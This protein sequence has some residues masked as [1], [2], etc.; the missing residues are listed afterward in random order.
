MDYSVRAA[1]TGEHSDNIRLASTATEDEWIH[2]ARLGMLMREQSSKLDLRWFS[3]VEYRDYRYDAFHDD[4][5]LM[6]NTAA[7]WTV[8]PQ[9]LNWVVE[10]YYGQALI[11]VTAAPTQDNL[12]DVNVLSLGPDAFWRVSERTYGRVGA[13]YGNYYTEATS[14]DADRYA[15]MASANY[16]LSSVTELSLNYD[17]LRAAQRDSENYRDYDRHNIFLGI[18]RRLPRSRLDLHVGQSLIRPEGEGTNTDHYWHAQWLRPVSP[19]TE[20]RVTATS[21]AQDA[22]DA[23]LAATAVASAP[24]SAQVLTYRF[25]EATLGYTRTRA[26]VSDQL[27]VFGQALDYDTQPLDEERAGGNVEIG[28]SVSATATGAVFGGFTRSDFIETGLLTRDSV[29]GVRLQ[30]RVRRHTTVGIEGRWSERQSNDPSREY[31][32]NRVMLTLSYN[33]DATVTGG[34][35]LET[36]LGR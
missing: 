4:T 16:L 21:R 18:A 9:R 15:L 12:Q 19:Q 7:T 23:V 30:Y 24:P 28:V 36:G 11:D 3:Q 20:F 35:R 29:A 6:L 27:R 8:A 17:G 31:T 5:I 2:V 26:G 10:D 34:G 1:Y 32:E 25:D 13:R 14:A 22:A 33:S